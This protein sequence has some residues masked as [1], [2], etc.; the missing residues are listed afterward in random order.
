[1]GPTLSS[2]TAF[3]G[4]SDFWEKG[5]EEQVLAVEVGFDE[6]KIRRVS[7]D[8][9]YSVSCSTELEFFA[10]HPFSCFWN[11]IRLTADVRNIGGG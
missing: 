1:M 2:I 11:W 3:K 4:F 8:D 6:L 7:R 5:V 9:S 10:C